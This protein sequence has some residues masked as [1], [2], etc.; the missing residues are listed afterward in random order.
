M[1]ENLRICCCYAHE[2]R[3]LL[4]GLQRYLHPL[5]RAGLINMWDDANISPG[6]EWKKEIREQ[7]QAAQIILLLVSTD[8]LNSDYCYSEEMQY[9]LERHH[10]NQARAIPII[11]LPSLWTV[12][13][14]ANLQALP[15]YGIP[16]ISERWSSQDEAF[17]DVAEGLR[18]VIEEL[19][20]DIQQPLS[21][22]TLAE[23][24]VAYGNVPRAVANAIL[25]LDSVDREQR[26]NGL[27]TL[28]QMKHPAAQEALIGALNHS[29]QDVRMQAAY[30]LKHD[31]RAIPV[32]VEMLYLYNNPLFFYQGT[33]GFASNLKSDA[34]QLRILAIDALCQIGEPAIPALIEALDNND[35]RVQVKAATALATLRDSRAVP[36]LIEALKNS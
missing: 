36:P 18:Q 12:T 1:K 6:L 33:A 32:L 5:Q 23:T 26:Y 2:D 35:V 27:Y 13:P 28:Q 29:I 25:A 4:E 34:N 15:K 30:L 11:L 7:L 8:F 21:S 9:A 14:L 22:A 3:P 19:S 24:A 20:S 31:R 10:S 17:Q 16:V